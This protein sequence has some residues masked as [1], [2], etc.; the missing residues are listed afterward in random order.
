VNL[1]D[2]RAGRFAVAF[3]RGTAA[4]I[5]D[6]WERV[7][8]AWLPDS[9]FAPDDQTAVEIYRG[10]PCGKSPRGVFRCELALPVRTL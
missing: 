6:A 2:V 1:A 5:E 3:F 4:E 7:F 9:G 10:A 8:S